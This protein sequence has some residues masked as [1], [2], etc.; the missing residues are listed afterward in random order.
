[1]KRKA[2]FFVTA[3]FAAILWAPVGQAADA[4]CLEIREMIVGN[5]YIAKVPMYDTKI[6]IDGITKLERD[7]DEIPKGATFKVLKVECESGKLEIK[8]RQVAHKKI[9]AVQVKF[10]LTKNQRLMP[11]AIEQFQTMMDY[12]WE[13]VPEEK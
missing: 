2:I 7:K 4:V 10:R 9:D 1:M 3:L 5:T 11:N 6:D 13:D 12:V 8:L